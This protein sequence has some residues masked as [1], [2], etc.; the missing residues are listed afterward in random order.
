M[1]PKEQRQLELALRLGEEAAAFIKSLQS[2]TTMPLPVAEAIKARLGTTIDTNAKT[3][4]SET[5]SVNE[6]G[7]ASYSVA[8]PPDGFVTV[9]VNGQPKNIPYYD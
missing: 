6:A 7:A 2:S 5:Q 4:A 1:T 3:A 9:Y 8:K